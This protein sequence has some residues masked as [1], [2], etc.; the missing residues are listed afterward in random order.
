MATTTSNNNIASVAPTALAQRINS[1]EDVRLIDVRTP[2]EFESVHAPAA[3]NVPLD[4]LDPD[5]INRESGGG[6]VHVICHSGSRSAAAACERLITGGCTNVVSVEG[7]TQAWE[8][9]GLPVVRGKQTIS[10]ERQ[11]R[12]GAGLLVLTGAVLALTVNTWF[13]LL[14]AFVGAGLTFAGITDICGMGL[15]LGRMPWNRAACHR[16]AS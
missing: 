4:T 1:G 6:T 2:A 14:P 10:L 9:A 15:L 3:R 11:V 16:C 12:I 13:A 8:A 5:A 7:G